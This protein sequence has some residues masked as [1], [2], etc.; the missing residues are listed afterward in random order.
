MTAGILE[1]FPLRM[2]NEDSSTGTTPSKV[3]VNT[4]AMINASQ[5]SNETRITPSVAYLTDAFASYE[6]SHALGSL[7]SSLSEA[8]RR[9]LT[10]YSI[11]LPSIQALAAEFVDQKLRAKCPSLPNPLKATAEDA[12]GLSWRGR[13]CW[14]SGE[15][16][17]DGRVEL[18]VRN[19]R[20]HRVESAEWSSGNPIP[21]EIVWALGVQ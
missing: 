1:M 15:V 13:D 17:K 7:A 18:F 19:D 11:T 16:Y 4:D 5:R 12:L 21:D 14:V 9:Q 6:Y 2:A 10:A 20:L 8:V 3:W